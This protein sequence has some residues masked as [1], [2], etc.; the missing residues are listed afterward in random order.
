MPQLLFSGFFVSTSSIPIYLRWLQWIMPLTYALRLVL[1]E[2]FEFCRNVLL[3]GG[4]YG[5]RD[6]DGKNSTTML[7][8]LISLQ[9]QQQQQQQ[10]SNITSDHYLNITSLAE[11]DHLAT[12]FD[13]ATAA[14]SSSSSSSSGI[15]Y[16]IE[17][18]E[19]NRADD[20]YTTTYWTMLLALGVLFR[21]LSSYFLWR[22]VQNK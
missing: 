14:A 3:S 7:N 8:F 20:E 4:G 16:C 15:S 1:N 17:Y 12:L 5:Y 19:T 9:Q 21:I 2:E 11:N 18:L 22:K 13:E 6:D 10:S